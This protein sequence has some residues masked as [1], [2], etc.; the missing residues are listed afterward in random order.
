[1]DFKARLKNPIFWITF[2]GL[3]LSTTR[4][5]SET[6]TSW[7]S[8]KDALLSVM[9]NPYLLGC[10]VVAVVGQVNDPSSTG[11]KDKE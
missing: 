5:N 10:F 4:I 9:G 6:L 7:I 11:L 8:L 2:I 3:F 1:M